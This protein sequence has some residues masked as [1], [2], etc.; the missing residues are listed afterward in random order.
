MGGLYCTSYTFIS[1]FFLLYSTLF[2]TKIGKL[3]LRVPSPNSMHIEVFT[4]TAAT[5]DKTSTLFV[6][7]KIHVR[8]KTNKC[9]I[10]LLLYGQIYFIFKVKLEINIFIVNY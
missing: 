10:I 2:Q 7:H 9:H 4:K 8:V 5:T 3:L 6:Y 1:L